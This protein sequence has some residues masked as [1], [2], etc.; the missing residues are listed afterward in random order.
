[1]LLIIYQSIINAHFSY[2]LLVWGSK[3]NNHPLHFLQK[4]APRIVKNTDYVAHSELICKDLRLLKMPDVFRF[5][6]WNFFFKLMNNK[7]PLYFENMKP[8]LPRICNNYDI[9]RPS[10][11]LPLIKPDFAEPFISYQLTTMLNENG[12][13]RFS[14]RVFTHSI[15]GFS[16]YPKMLLL[17]DI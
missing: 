5:T 13:T 16:Y 11:Y 15:S 8:V 1:M 17:I 14:S 10:F 2:G 9:R 4:K 7:L 6:L 3:I 12:S